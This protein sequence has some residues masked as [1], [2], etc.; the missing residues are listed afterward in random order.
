MHTI[1]VNG[2]GR[3][4]CGDD[5]TILEA[6]QRAGFS[7]PVAC[8][9][10]VCERCRGEL[11][12]GSVRIERH[13]H[14]IHAGETGSN[15]VLYCVAHTLTDCEIHVP[16]VR[17]PGQLPV[18]EV[19]CQIVDV[20]DLNADVARVLLRLP[21]GKRIDWYAGQYLE[22]LF[23]FGDCA[24]SI[25]NAPG[26]RDIELHVRYGAD[27]SSSL[28]VIAALRNDSLVKVRLPGGQRF[29]DELPQQPVWF[30]CG[31]T[32]FA[33]VKAML[34]KL[35]NDGFTLPVRLYWG[36]RTVSD[37]YLHDIASAFAAEMPNLAYVPALSEEQRDGMFAG[38]VHEAVLNDLKL[39]DGVTPPLFY[40]GGSVPMA[41]AVFDALVAAGVPAENIHS[42]VYDYAPR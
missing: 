35:R 16:E 9:N 21:A 37:L 1:I 30:I 28:D 2:V 41:W 20:S 13:G 27:N 38:L 33:P 39:L 4:S 5:E 15:A 24:F 34:E 29:I 19:T 8:R 31:S 23:P 3:F 18:H 12:S 10:G 40:V 25:A 14:T 32:G 17:A 26:G 7:F 11:I 36:A 6:G 22:L 42:D